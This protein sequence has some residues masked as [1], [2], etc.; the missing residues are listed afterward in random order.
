MP[1]PY[2]LYLLSVTNVFTQKQRPTPKA[3]GTKRCLKYYLFILC[4]NIHFTAQEFGLFA[5]PVIDKD[6]YAGELFA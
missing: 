4:W 6:F 1:C 5:Q 3:I 2:C